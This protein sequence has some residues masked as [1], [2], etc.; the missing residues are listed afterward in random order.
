MRRSQAQRLISAPA[1][2][3]IPFETPVIPVPPW[4]D[5][6]DC[7]FERPCLANDTSTGGRGP[8]TPAL[9]LGGRPP[10]IGTGKDVLDVVVH[11]HD[12]QFAALL[13]IMPGQLRIGF[14]PKPLADFFLRSSRQACPGLFFAARD[15]KMRRFIAACQGPECRSQEAGVRRQQVAQSSAPMHQSLAGSCP[16]GIWN[17]QSRIAP[18]WRSHLPL[19]TRALWARASL[20]S[21]ISN[22]PQVAQPSAPTHPRLAGSCPSGIWNLQSRIAPRCACPES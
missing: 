14:P 7:G 13:A 12:V 9:P 19:R 18:R 20:K 2:A 16:S 21:G 10:S 15:G 6:N 17:L 1:W 8:V 5:G 3:G 22:R 4:R 11:Q